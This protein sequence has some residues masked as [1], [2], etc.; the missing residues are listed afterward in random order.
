MCADTGYEAQPSYPSIFDRLV[1]LGTLDLGRVVCSTVLSR[2]SRDLYRPVSRVLLAVDCQLFAPETLGLAVVGC[3]QR[4]RWKKSLF[5]LCALV[6]PRM[7][8]PGIYVFPSGEI[9]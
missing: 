8:R 1:R 6:F 2:V 7:V 5:F 4:W 9:Y 3:R